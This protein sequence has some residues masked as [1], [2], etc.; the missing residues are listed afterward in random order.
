MVI[1]KWPFEL[2]KVYVIF[3][4]G[5]LSKS[6]SALKDNKRIATL[7]P[8]A[9]Q[10]ITNFYQQMKGDMGKKLAALHSTPLH[11]QRNYCQM[12]KEIAEEQRFEVTYVD[13]KDLSATG[14]SAYSTVKCWD[15]FLKSWRIFWVSIRAVHRTKF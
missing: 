14:K 2:F 13:I 9:S 3:Q 8:Q 6:Y 1:A 10:K 11:M 5:D 4:P 12:L 7:T 15:W